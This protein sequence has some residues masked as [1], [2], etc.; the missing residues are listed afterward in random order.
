MQQDLH[1]LIIDPQNDFC[2]LPNNY[3][4]VN[5]IT[6]NF[7]MPALPVTGSHNDMLKIAGII[8]S[9]MDG[10]ANITVTMDLHHRN[11]IS[12]PV[13]WIKADGSMV[14]P[15]TEI[16]SADIKS[17]KYLT[18]NPKNLKRALNY[19]EML[20]A[21]ERYLLIIWPIHCEIGSWGQNIHF[22]VKNAYNLWEEKTGKNINVI[23]KGMNPWT[24]H[25]S[26][27]QAEIPDLN[28]DD[29]KTNQKFINSLK[30]ADKV[31]ITG[32][33]ASHCVKST[34]EHIVENFEPKHL[35]KLVIVTDCMSAITGFEKQYQQFL[36]EMQEKG[37]QISKSSDVIT[38]ILKNTKNL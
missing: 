27:V 7:I 38:E 25:Y 18:K 19:V 3:L 34:T 12:H 31:Y 6:N 37:L 22:D 5:P 35:S 21:N 10:I 32:E 4:P 24:E 2:D 17:K 26:A 1:L 14:E 11:D 28:D 15:F 30:K 33:A 20:E 16:S 36:N 9:G 13:F 29:T 8:K 23:N